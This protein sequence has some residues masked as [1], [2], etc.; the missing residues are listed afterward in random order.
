[1]LIDRTVSAP[2]LVFAHCRS[3]LLRPKPGGFEAL[4]TQP[5]RLKRTLEAQVILGPT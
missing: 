1:V 4:A 3:A 2:L 5:E